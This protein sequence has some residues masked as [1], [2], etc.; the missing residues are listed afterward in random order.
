MILTAAKELLHFLRPGAAYDN[1]PLLIVCFDEA[2]MLTDQDHN[3]ART[4]FGELRRALRIIRLL[5]IFTIFVSTVG[6]LEQVSPLPQLAPSDR[7][8]YM[9]LNPFPPIVCTPFD[10]LYPPTSRDK[11]WTLKEVASTYHM[12]HLGRAL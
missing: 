3:R 6:H 12:A 9:T 1:E 7:L 8:G 4:L 2:S 10:V 5:P 11:S